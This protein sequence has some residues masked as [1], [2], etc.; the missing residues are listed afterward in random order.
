M[1]CNFYNIGE[2]ATED[3]G[4]YPPQYTEQYIGGDRCHDSSPTIIDLK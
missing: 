4:I 1:D 2:I 3:E